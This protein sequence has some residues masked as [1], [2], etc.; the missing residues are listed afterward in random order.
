MTMQEKLKAL[1]DEGLEFSQCVQAFGVGEDNP[2]AKAAADMYAS[3]G[4]VEIDTTTVLSTSDEGAYVMAWV[5][6]GNSDADA[7]S[8]T[9]ASEA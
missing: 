6:V 9:E 5:W 1:I 2:F 8:A 3:E 4:S 7:H